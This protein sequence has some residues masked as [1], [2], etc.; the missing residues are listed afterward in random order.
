VRQRDREHARTSAPDHQARPPGRRRNQHCVLGLPVAPAERHPFTGQQAAHDR[1][2]LLE[3]R[4]PVIEGKPEGPELRLIPAGPEA[5]HETAVTDLA[6]RRGH[7]RDQP[8]GMKRGTRFERPKLN[9]LGRGGERRQHRPGLP[10]PTFGATVAAVKQVIADP[11]RIKAARLGGA[12]HRQVF[13]P[14]DPPLYL[15]KLN[16]YS[17]RSRHS[18]RSTQRNLRDEPA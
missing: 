16:P 10:W 2:G 6:D 7:L 9:P 15:R 17:Q 1:E 11:D 18:K 3:T 5:E 8:G 13:R 4:H 12:R 14:A